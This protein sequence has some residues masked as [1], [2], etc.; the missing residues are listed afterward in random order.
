MFNGK[1]T[2]LIIISV[3]LY[4]EVWP[5]DQSGSGEVIIC[6]NPHVFQSS[7]HEYEIRGKWPQCDYGPLLVFCPALPGYISNF[8][9]HLMLL[10]LLPQFTTVCQRW[11]KQAH[12]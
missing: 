6:Q 12:S 9:H 11:R 5:V 1:A 2:F 10:L 8:P 7:H 3:L 4:G